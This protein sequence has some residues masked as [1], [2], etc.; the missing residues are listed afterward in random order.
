MSL[1]TT[2]QSDYELRLPQE[3]VKY[4]MLGGSEVVVG[5][6]IAPYDLM[7]LRLSQERAKYAMLGGSEVVVGISIAS[8]D[9]M[10]ASLCCGDP[11]PRPRPPSLHALHATSQSDSEL[12]LPQERVEYAMLGG[13]EV[14]VGTSIASYDLMHASWCCDDPPPRR[15]IYDHDQRPK[16]ISQRVLVVLCCDL[17]STRLTNVAHHAI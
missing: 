17:A 15:V 3:R 16:C 8:Y 12:R 5:T 13:S 14:V 4:A 11:P 1:R 7:Q 9:V 6:S 2:S 10:H